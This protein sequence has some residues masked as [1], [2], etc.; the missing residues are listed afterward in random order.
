[1]QEN[2]SIFSD[3]KQKRE[4]LAAKKAPRASGKKRDAKV[5][6]Y[7]EKKLCIITAKI[8]RDHATKKPE[9]KYDIQ[10]AHNAT[11]SFL[12]DI[13]GDKKAADIVKQQK[14][15]NGL[16]KA[17]Q[18]KKQS[19]KSALLPAELAAD[20]LKTIKKNSEQVKRENSVIIAADIIKQQQE[21]LKLKLEKW[22]QEQ[23]KKAEQAA[24]RKAA[25]EKRKAAKAEKAATATATAS[26]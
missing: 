8:Y 11:G 22:Q 5:Q 12:A 15:Y 17:E 10:L 13:Y 23:A 26:K 7:N 2:K 16:S 24:K 19:G 14:K 3:I 6:A 20:I 25:A 1:M 9:L 18:A 21:K 4:K